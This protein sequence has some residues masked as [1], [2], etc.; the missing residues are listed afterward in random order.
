MLF[1]CPSVVY[2]LFL[3]CHQEEKDVSRIF[4]NLSIDLLIERRHVIC[5]EVE[6]DRVD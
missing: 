5:F 3:A 2:S 4:C 1:F 6:I